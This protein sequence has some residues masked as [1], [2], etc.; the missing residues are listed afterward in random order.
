MAPIQF[1][2]A[3]YLFNTGVEGREFSVHFIELKIIG[4]QASVNIFESRCFMLEKFLCHGTRG[5]TKSTISLRDNE[6]FGSFE[7]FDIS[8]SCALGD[9]S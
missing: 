2:I 7:T 9:F 4:Y 1:T 8:L 3:D 6:Q 5:G